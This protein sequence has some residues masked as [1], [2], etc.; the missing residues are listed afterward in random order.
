[1]RNRIQAALVAFL[2]F[3]SIAAPVAAGP[4]EDADAAYRCGDYST[5]FW[6]VRPLAEHGDALAQSMRGLIYRD[7]HGVPQDYTEAASWFRKAADQDSPVAQFNLGFLSNR[8]ERRPPFRV[9]S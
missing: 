1:V 7:G 6:L 3:V 2:A 4:F 8:F 9:Q 5:A